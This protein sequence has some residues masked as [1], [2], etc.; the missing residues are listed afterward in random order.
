MPTEIIFL[1]EIG[2][3]LETQAKLL[4]VMQGGVHAPRRL[5]IIKVDVHIIAATNVD[6]KKTMEEG[7][8]GGSVLAERRQR[9]P[10]ATADRKDDIL[11]LRALE[12]AGRKTASRISSLCRKRSIC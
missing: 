3:I 5:E 8:S 4:R 2:N 11:C 1:D 9:R 6:L 10:P 12:N 7:A